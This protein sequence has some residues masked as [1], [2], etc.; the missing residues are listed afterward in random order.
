MSAVAEPERKVDGGEGQICAA[1]RNDKNPEQNLALPPLWWG[2][3]RRR[4]GLHHLETHRCLG[5]G[6][7]GPNLLSSCSEKAAMSQSREAESRQARVRQ[8][9]A[10][11]CTILQ[12]NENTMS[13]K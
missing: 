4:D 5:E 3:M 10:C 12:Y 13:P 2:S 8:R 1:L 11:P 6:H 9:G 7:N